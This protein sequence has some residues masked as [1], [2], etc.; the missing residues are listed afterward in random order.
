MYLSVGVVWDS[1]NWHRVLVVEFT[2][3]L[4]EGFI[5]VLVIGFTI[6]FSDHKHYNVS[7]T[8]NQS[9]YFVVAVHFVAP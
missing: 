9:V 6:N 7:Q 1:L 2:D 5:D 3:V 8:V 4:V